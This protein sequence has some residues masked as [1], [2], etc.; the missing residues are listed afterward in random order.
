MIN[1]LHFSSNLKKLEKYVND[2]NLVFKRLK[3]HFSIIQVILK[4]MINVLH[5]SSNFQVTFKLLKRA[6]KNLMKMS[7]SLQV[8]ESFISFL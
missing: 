6:F 7:S 5:F 8:F 4:H 3:A 2:L 1:V